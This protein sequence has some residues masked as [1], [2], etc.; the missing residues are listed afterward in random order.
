MTLEVTGKNLLVVMIFQ[1]VYM[2]MVTMKI[3]V[4]LRKC[5][6]VNGSRMLGDGKMLIGRYR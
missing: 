2:L 1:A 5:I 3:M 4:R 6:S